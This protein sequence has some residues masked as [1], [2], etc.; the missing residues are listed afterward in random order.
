M[1]SPGSD[2]KQED[3]NLQPHLAV[4]VKATHPAGSKRSA[5]APKLPA[6]PATTP[7]VAGLPGIAPAPAPATPPPPPA[8][9]LSAVLPVPAC[10]EVLAEP[11]ARVSW[12]T[13]P[14][15][16]PAPVAPWPPWGV[17]EAGGGRA[18][19]HCPFP[20]N[21]T[22]A[23]VSMSRTTKWST[24]MPQQISPPPSGCRH[25][26]IA[27]CTVS[28]REVTAEFSCTQMDGRNKERPRKQ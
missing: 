5:C 22:Q 14:L 27:S 23:L 4:T 26:W 17:A 19:S 9:A 6:P 8:P 12:D 25:T 1:I 18:P 13:P 20:E 2:G 16:W 28:E 7:P 10:C 3:F 24:L 11:R 15:L 21:S